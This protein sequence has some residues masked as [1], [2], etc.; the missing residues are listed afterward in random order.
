MSS[1]ERCAR[2]GECTP[3]PQSVGSWAGVNGPGD[4]GPQ[5][6]CSQSE[7]RDENEASLEERNFT[8]MN[9]SKHPVTKLTTEARKVDPVANPKAARK[10][11]PVAT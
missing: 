8:T 5:G 9:F 6:I 1:T 3:G 2:T 10:Q 7:A 11:S 4:S